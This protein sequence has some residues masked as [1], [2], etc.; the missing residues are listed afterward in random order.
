VLKPN[1]TII[2]SFPFNP[3]QEKTL[4]RA[5]IEG[6]G[7]IVHIESPE[8]HGNPVDAEGGSLVFTEP[9]W[10]VLE[11]LREGGLANAAMA[12]VASAKHGVTANGPPGVFVLTATKTT[13]IRR[14]RQKLFAPKGLPEKLC[15][16]IALPRSGTTL[17]TSMFQV[18]SK[19]ETV[20]E[21]WNSK[22]LSGAA[23]ATL[24]TLTQKAGILE[25]RG[26]YLF[27]KETSADPSYITFLGR[28]FEQT[29]LPTDKHL[30]MLLRR[31][32]HTFLSEIERRA[33]WW[34]EDVAVNENQFS[35]WCQKSAHS[36]SS[37]L[38]LLIAQ[39][40]QL[41]S[42]EKLAEDP[43]ATLSQLAHYIGFGLEPTQLEYEK[44]LDRS[45]VRGDV[46]VANTPAEIS[47]AST[48]RRKL[49]EHSVDQLLETSDFS[50][51]VRTLNELHEQ[52]YQTGTLNIR[53]VNPVLIEKLTNPSGNSH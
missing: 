5:R 50:D 26:K 12:F 21:P 43:R 37:M 2:S 48:E 32:A 8:Y 25:P 7:Q 44:H 51:W 34:G 35:L 14:T 33:E 4:V 38:R 46:N 15:G 45:Q 24:Q 3:N 30:L 13:E 18:H 10:D 42:Y 20:Y 29:I 28:L 19:F 47:S 17:L 11:T 41:L 16:L 1:G 49:N 39:D 27:V 23:D 22:L 52:V 53:K 40:G 6:D 9:G 31:P 36:I